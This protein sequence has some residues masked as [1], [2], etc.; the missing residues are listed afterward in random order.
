MIQLPLTIGKF[1]FQN[2]GLEL[3]LGLIQSH[4][5]ASEVA[6]AAARTFALLLV[7]NYANQSLVGSFWRRDWRLRAGNPKPETPAWPITNDAI[8]NGAVSKQCFFFDA[9]LDAE[10][11]SD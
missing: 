4:A 11:G 7:N 5:Q 8:T 1:C 2:G 9:Y 3:L 6:V 10:G